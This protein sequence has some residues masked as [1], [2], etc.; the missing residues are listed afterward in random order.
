MKKKKVSAPPSKIPQ[1]EKTVVIPPDLQMKW[2]GCG[3]VATSFS[4]LD[5]GYFPHSYGTAVKQSLQFLAKL[6]E[7]MVEEALKHPQ[8]HMIPEL[9]QVLDQQ[10]KGAT[11][12]EKT[13]AN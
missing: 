8:A 7:N 2:D 10:K 1:S 5:K 9:K 4:V 11:D 3:A 6:H 13:A 12:G